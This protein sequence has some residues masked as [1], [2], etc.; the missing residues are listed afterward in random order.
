MGHLL[1]RFKMRSNEHTLIFFIN[2]FFVVKL[3]VSASRM[4]NDFVHVAPAGATNAQ[5]LRSAS[6]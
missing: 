2:F 3:K 5:L 6:S 1:V 4:K